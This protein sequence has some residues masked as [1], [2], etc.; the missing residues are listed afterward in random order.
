MCWKLKEVITHLRA[1]CH[2]IR[3]HA[4]HRIHELADKVQ[5][6]CRVQRECGMLMEKFE[7]LCH[8]EDIMR[9]EIVS[10]TVVTKT[11]VK[12]VIVVQE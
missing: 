4:H 11:V 5:T 12:D 2:R 8:V 7:G 1:E 10:E 9:E 6:F 3:Q